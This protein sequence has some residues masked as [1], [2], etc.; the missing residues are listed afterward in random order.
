M[1]WMVV[2]LH[3]LVCVGILEVAGL[4][5]CKGTSLS[6]LHR[7]VVAAEALAVH[8]VVVVLTIVGYIERGIIVPDD[9]L[10]AGILALVVYANGIG[11]APCIG[12]PARVGA[13]GDGIGAVR[14][15]A[16]PLVE[17]IADQLAHG[18]LVGA[19]QRQ[20]DVAASEVG[21]GV[22][23]VDVIGGI[24]APDDRGGQQDAGRL[25][26]EVFHA[27]LFAGLFDQLLENGQKFGIAA[28]GDD[29][30]VEL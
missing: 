21:G 22:E 3:F 29:F 20:V 24:C 25:K 4:G 2:E 10:L 14:I 17:F 13:V 28:V 27:K 11:L 30:G 5:A 6:R 16:D 7:T 1:V 15:L 19:A 9:L 12:N 23:F 8:V 26:Q 18:D